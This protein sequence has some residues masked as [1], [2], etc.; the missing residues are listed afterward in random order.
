MCRS[1]SVDL[2]YDPPMAL[3]YHTICLIFYIVE[4]DTGNRNNQIIL[5]QH[6]IH[7]T[8]VLSFQLLQITM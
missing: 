5:L 7:I 6:I 2:K 1:T 8:S 4:S 3:K